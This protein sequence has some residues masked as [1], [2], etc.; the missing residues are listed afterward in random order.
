MTLSKINRNQLNTGI[1]DSSDANAIVI[2]SNESVGIGSAVTTSDLNIGKGLNSNYTGIQF[3]SPNTASGTII[4][5]GDSTDNDYSSITAFASNA[6]ENGRMR[7]IAGT[8]EAMNIYNNGIVSKPS[9]PAFQ[10]YYANNSYCWS[11]TTDGGFHLQTLNQTRFNTGN[12]YNT[13]N[14]RFVAPVAGRYY[15]Y[16]QFY[17]NYTSNYARASAAIFLNGS[18]MTETWNPGTDT[19]MSGHTAITLSL[20]ANDYVQLY[21]AVYDQNATSNTYNIY[22]GALNTYLTGHLL[23]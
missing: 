7:F 6:G 22:C 8:N 20:A 14:H 5:F 13:T 2:N 18:Q 12:H 4:Y 3:T 23:G 21:A 16:G 10:A 9:T 11:D 19:G 17:T 1:S 15:F